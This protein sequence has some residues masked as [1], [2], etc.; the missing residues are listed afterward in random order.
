MY[1]DN[2]DIPSGIQAELL[3]GVSGIPNGNVD[4]SGN[5]GRMTHIL[6]YIDKIKIF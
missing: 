5:I 6:Q 4:S 3:A 2:K 1:T